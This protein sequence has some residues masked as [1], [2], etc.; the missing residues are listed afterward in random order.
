MIL[1][2]I[3]DLL[4]PAQRKTIFGLVAMMIVMAILDLA[5]VALIVPFLGIVANPDI[6]ETRDGLSAL[7]E[8]LGFETTLGFLQFLGFSLF[9]L[10]I[11]GIAARAA[12]FYAITR[13]VRSTVQSLAITL[14]ERYLAQP[15]EYFLPRN[16]AE[17][18]KSILAEAA[19]VVNQAIAPAVRILANGLVVAA[20]LCVLLWL[21]P[22]GALV[23][24]LVIG[25]AFFVVYRNVRSRLLSIGEARLQA[26]EERFRITQEAM[27]GIKEVKLLGLEKLYA[28]R[29]IDPSKRLAKHQASIQLIGDMPHFFLEALC[30]GGMLMFVLWLLA[31]RDGQIAEVLPVIG[32]FAFAGIKLMPVTKQ[33]FRDVAAL[34]AGAPSLDEIHKDLASL[35][36]L[37]RGETPKP[38]ALTNEVSLKNIT[39]H[40]PGSE[41]KVLRGLNLTIPARQSVGIVGS[42]GAGK[43]TIL[44]IILGL[45]E[46]AEGEVVV[47]GVSITRAN[48]AAWQ[49][50]IGYVPQK[51]FL[52]DDTIAANIAYGR[53]AK[54]ITREDILRAA[55]QASLTDMLAELPDGIDTQVGE[56]GIRLSGGQR[57]RIGIA[58]ALVHDP[59]LLVFDE[60][61]SALDTLTERTVMEAIGALSGRKT[62]VIVTHRLE[63]V[64]NCDRTVLL[65]HGEIIAEGPF[66]RLEAESEEFRSMVHA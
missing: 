48:R 8:R 45:L 32:A 24:G 25:V 49:Q 60:A 29:F 21:E 39:Y 53:D 5:G 2:K 65:S 63:S 11:A 7:N 64:R 58:R 52:T 41:K 36:P 22:L 9:L 61:T 15:Y 38:L 26:A 66:D 54:A 34:R 17:I 44:D 30:F 51:I 35:S 6:L 1:S 19:Y 16:S 40:Y 43:T 55:E 10:V 13:F 23:A 4:T 20:M 46:P 47:D 37:V 3:H 33:V 18:G 27:A 56:D 31:T 14:L 57:Q 12:T 28:D 50:S 42:T 59:A 62:M